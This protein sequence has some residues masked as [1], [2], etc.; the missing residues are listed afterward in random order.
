MF[1]QV[2]GKSSSI[3]SFSDNTKV[4]FIGTDRLRELYPAAVKLPKRAA[5]P[6]PAWPPSTAA[7][8]ARPK[9]AAT[10]WFIAAFGLP[11]TG[12]IDVVA[13]A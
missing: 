8:R 9:S 4:W 3:V 2:S 11:A 1:V 13:A 7:S 5:N 6:K 10:N 12:S